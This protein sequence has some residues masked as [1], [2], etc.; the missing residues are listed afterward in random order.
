MSF[1][2]H[3]AV[4]QGYPE[5]PIRVVVGFTPG[6]GADAVARLIA[7][8]LQQTWRQTVVV[9]NRPGAGGNVG[10]EIV[11]KS[12]PDGYTLLLTS[13]GPVTVNQSLMHNLPYNP[14]RDLAPI[15]LIA[16]APNV[17]VVP[18]ASPATGIK[19][20]IAL[21]RTS[22]KRLNYGSSGPGSTPHLSAELF[23]MMAGVD[24]IHI[25]FKGAGPAVI[26]LVAGRL[27]V[28]IVAAGTASA[29]VQARRLRALAVTS[30]RRSSILSD[31]PTLDESALPGYESGVWWGLLAPA[32]TP[33]AVVTRLHEA[34]VA[35]LRTAETRSRLESGEGAE[36]V[37]NAPGEFAEFMRRETIKWARVIKAAG[38]KPD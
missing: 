33:A 13:P 6:G 1:V 28:M 26:D 31:V 34:V 23:K 10:T 36:V 30:L 11:A 18:S 22:P 7:H 17:V 35:S 32:G 24:M 9:D 25:A 3:A 29:Q 4:A 14:S 20:L 5:K 38:I 16:F 19:E 21:A 37:G 2:A 15:T 27:D 8:N 12:N